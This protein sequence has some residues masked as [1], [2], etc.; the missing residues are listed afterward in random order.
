MGN[1]F[2]LIVTRESIQEQFIRM[3]DHLKNK[4][5]AYTTEGSYP[6]TRIETEEVTRYD[7]HRQDFSRYGLK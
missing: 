5:Q 2:L 1:V 4:Q 6:Q 7:H 3:F